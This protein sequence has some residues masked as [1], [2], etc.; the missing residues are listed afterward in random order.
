M[1]TFASDPAPWVL[2]WLLL[3]DFLMLLWVCWLAAKNPPP[4]STPSTLDHVQDQVVNEEE[5]GREQN[6]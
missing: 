1:S 3:A 2:G 6:P 5:S 4:H